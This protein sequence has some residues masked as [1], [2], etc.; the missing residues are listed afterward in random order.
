MQE[1]GLGKA[2]QDVYEG[3]RSLWWERDINGK[4]TGILR[5][6]TVVCV[7]SN[8]TEMKV[9]NLNSLDST[10]GFGQIFLDGSFALKM[11]FRVSQVYPSSPQASTL[12]HRL[13][14]DTTPQLRCPH[15]PLR[16]T[17]VEGKIQVLMW[18]YIWGSGFQTWI[19][20]S[21]LSS[22]PQTNTLNC[23]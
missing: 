15:F 6:T 18:S 22:E 8:I 20:K 21:V 19:L 17:W 7:H 11:G 5:G 2:F 16:P 13:P 9:N 4:E 3:W 10:F 23:L 14:L 1:L 12:K